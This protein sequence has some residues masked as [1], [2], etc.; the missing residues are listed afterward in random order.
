MC[1]CMSVYTQIMRELSARHIMSHHFA[2]PVWRGGHVEWRGRRDYVDVC[3]Y[4][5]LQ[6]GHVRC[7]R[8]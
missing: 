8:G 6:V 5:A 7:H 3:A 4:V 1:K 2:G